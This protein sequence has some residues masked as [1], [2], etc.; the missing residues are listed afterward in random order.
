M[1]TSIRR[2]FT[3]Q[4]LTAWL[5]GVALLFLPSCGGSST[6]S[7]P[8]SPVDYFK[9]KQGGIST[10]HGKIQGDSVREG[11]DGKI[12]YRTENG[13]NWQVEMKQKADGTY[14]YGEPVEVKK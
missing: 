7:K 9:K 2:A 4:A 3:R 10:P 8:L 11:Q 6:P 1:R 13:T 14:S 12:Q 5:L